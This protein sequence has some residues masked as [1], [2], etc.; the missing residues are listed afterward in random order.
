MI[1]VDFL[2]GG[3]RVCVSRVG[4][5]KERGRGTR[6]CLRT[7]AAPKNPATQQRLRRDRRPTPRTGR[8]RKRR[9]PNG[10]VRNDPLSVRSQ[11]DHLAEDS[12]DQLLSIVVVVR[13]MCTPM[14][15]F[16]D[17]LTLRVEDCQAGSL[18]ENEGE[19]QI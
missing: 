1:H 7:P 2:D 13:H 12:P 18:L 8:S 4:G 16:G 11:L 19:I 3:L 10:A 15:L 14:C 6:P 17:S 5:G 9:S